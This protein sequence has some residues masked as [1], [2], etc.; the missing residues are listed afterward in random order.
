LQQSKLRIAYPLGRTSTSPVSLVLYRINPDHQCSPSEPPDIMSDKPNTSGSSTRTPPSND[1]HSPARPRRSS[2]AADTLAG[3]FGGT[4]SSGQARSVID[5]TN[6]ESS[7]NLSA[8]P[9]TEG[10][11]T[12]A[13]RRLSM[14]TFGNLSN[15]SGAN[16][17][18]RREST[19]SSSV[20]GLND[21]AIDEDEPLSAIDSST[22]TPFSRRLSTNARSMRDVR[23]NSMAGGSPKEGF[24]WSENFRTRAERAS[25]IATIGSVGGMNG[26]G[27]HRSVSVMD[28][29]PP[30]PKPQPP[31]QEIP[32]PKERPRPD[33]FQERI[34]KGDFYM[35]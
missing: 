8:S 2:I 23:S 17:H 32:K 31:A 16:G 29:P 21:S 15:N 20:G 10:P 30:Q 13:A 12:S 6:N 26:H 9:S 35:D 25:S 14:T 34:L 24:N 3:I 33:H 1:S 7:N 5:T 19:M 22:H 18:N 11:I 4:R 28:S 27:R